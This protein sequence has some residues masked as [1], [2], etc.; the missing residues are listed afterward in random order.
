MSVR[1]FIPGDAGALAVGAD[2]VTAALRQAAGERNV[3][4]QVIRT[5]SRGLY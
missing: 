5:G 1:I 3:V 2:E 4:L